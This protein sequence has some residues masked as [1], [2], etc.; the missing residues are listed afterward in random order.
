MTTPT[1]INNLMQLFDLNTNNNNQTISD[2]DSSQISTILQWKHSNN[3]KNY[4]ESKTIGAIT[5]KKLED[6][7]ADKK[8]INITINPINNSLPENIGLKISNVD[9]KIGTNLSMGYNTEG[10]EYNCV[11]S[12][13]KISKLLSE[14]S[15]NEF[16]VAKFNKDCAMIHGNYELLG[17]SETIKMLK[18][19]EANAILCNLNP[20]E[21]NGEIYYKM[22]PDV[23]EKIEKSITAT[24][25]NNKLVEIEL[26]SISNI[27]FQ[28]VPLVHENFS[29][30]FKNS[31]SIQN[32]KAIKNSTQQV[33][34][35]EITLEISFK[36]DEN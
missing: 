12:N 30:L 5:A 3:H 33:D 26:P 35:H 18:K 31:I 27:E 9:N 8:I 32:S 14:V 15:Q 11:L 22:S 2:I 29:D 16:T 21:L 20:S 17:S 23:K 28:L 24:N 25:N 13:G 34:N 1:N 6:A 4:D 19:N 36:F 10:K 7:L